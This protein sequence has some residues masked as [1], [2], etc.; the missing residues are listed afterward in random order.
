MTVRR[1]MSTHGPAAAMPA[2]APSPFER[3]RL[4]DVVAAVLGLQLDI[5]G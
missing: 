1:L 2:A 5:A 3:Q 4:R